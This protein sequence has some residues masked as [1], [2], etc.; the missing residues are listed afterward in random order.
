MYGTKWKSYV[1][2]HSK[3]L[4]KTDDFVFWGYSYF[5]HSKIAYK[6]IK[7]LQKMEDI[8]HIHKKWANFKLTF[9]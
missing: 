1:V 2:T 3:Q 6:Q 7:N 4:T 9:Q 5:L 8:M